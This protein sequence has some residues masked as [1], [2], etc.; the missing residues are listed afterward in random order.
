MAVKSL[1]RSKSSEIL[2]TD[3]YKAPCYFGCVTE[4]KD[5]FAVSL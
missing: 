1:F 2:G 4:S 3:W 5:K